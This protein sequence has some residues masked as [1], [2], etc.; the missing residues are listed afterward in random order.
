MKR[1]ATLKAGDI[2]S[3]ISDL[4]KK[5]ANE[6]KILEKN[7]SVWAFSQLL[8][9]VNHIHEDFKPRNMEVIF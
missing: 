2:N 9:S 6:I 1:I 5:L 4:E 3:F 7:H 8:N